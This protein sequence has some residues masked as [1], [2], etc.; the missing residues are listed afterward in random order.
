M[1]HVVEHTGTKKS[2][3]QKNMLHHKRP[4]PGTLTCYNCTAALHQ[5]LPSTFS[6]RTYI[7]PLGSFYLDYPKKH[8][9]A[10]Q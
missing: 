5:G 9:F 10:L 8:Y 1:M 6:V 7:E 3:S 4:R 2:K